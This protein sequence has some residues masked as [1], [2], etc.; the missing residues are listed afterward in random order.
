MSEHKDKLKKEPENN[1]NQVEQHTETERK[2]DDY[3][4]NFLPLGLCLGI[5]FG[6]IFK[7]LAVGISLGL[8]FGIALG[9]FSKEK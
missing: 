1:K 3:S 7:Q 6:L 2:K 5:A 9:T 8:C 4:A